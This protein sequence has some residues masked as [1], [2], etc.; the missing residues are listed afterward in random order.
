M[1][2]RYSKNNQSKTFLAPKH[3]YHC[4]VVFEFRS[5]EIN[6]TL[7]NQQLYSN[8]IYLASQL[9][10]YRNLRDLTVGE[11]RRITRPKRFTKT[12]SPKDASSLPGRRLEQ[13]TPDRWRFRSI[14]PTDVQLMTEKVEVVDDVCPRGQTC[15]VGP[16]KA[17]LG[18]KDKNIETLSPLQQHLPRET[19][20]F[21]PPRAASVGTGRQPAFVRRL[22]NRFPGAC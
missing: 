2:F 21:P 18:E 17:P 3:V 9:L 12:S 14:I 20:D 15:Q 8:R 5:L 10:S 19:A 22:C 16:D 4:A 11:L 6:Q 13:T 7:P 1:G